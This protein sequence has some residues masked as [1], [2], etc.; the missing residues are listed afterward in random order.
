MKKI[1]YYLREF[2]YYIRYD[3]SYGIKNLISWFPT[4][5]NQRDYDYS[6]IYDVLI[7]KLEKTLKCIDKYSFELEE[8][9]Q[10]RLRDIKL[11]ISLL[12]LIRSDFYG[13]EYSDY[14]EAEYDFIE[15]NDGSN[16]SRMEVKYS[17]NDRLQEYLNKYPNRLTSIRK[18]IGIFT[19]ET[20]EDRISIAIKVSKLN[21]EKALKLLFKILH[22]KIEGFWY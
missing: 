7:F 15:L 6:Y 11:C 10:I 12:K 4:I 22:D 5:W 18:R 19:L 3:I 21:H 2:S 20:V 1:K 16:C 17:E 9:K 13:S 8:D 14:Y